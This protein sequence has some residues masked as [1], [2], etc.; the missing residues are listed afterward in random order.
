[1]K[2][3]YLFLLAVGSLLYSNSV[4]QTIQ[5]VDNDYWIVVPANYFTLGGSN[6]ENRPRLA[7][8]A[9]K[10]TNVTVE[11]AA[12]TYNVIANQSGM[13]IPHP[14]PM[15]FSHKRILKRG[16]HAWSTDSLP[17]RAQLL[18]TP[19]EWGEGTWCIPTHSLGMN[20]R[21]ANYNTH[22]DIHHPDVYFGL[23]NG[24]E[25]AIVATEV[26][27]HVTIDFPPGHNLAPIVIVLNAGEAYHIDCGKPDVNIDPTGTRITANKR[28]AV[29]S[30]QA[31]AVIPTN[32]GGYGNA[33][34]EEM[35]PIE[36]WGK[37]HMI[38][39]SPRH[40]A[41]I[42]RFL[43]DCDS[44]KVYNDGNLIATINGGQF[45]ETQLSGAHEIYSSKPIMVGEYNQAGT[46]LYSDEGGP[47]ML[48][49]PPVDCYFDSTRFY[50]T[51]IP[52]V[53]NVGTGKGLPAVMVIV[54]SAYITNVQFDGL[55][56]IGFATITNTYSPIQY[57]YAYVQIAL[58]SAGAHTLNYITPPAANPY[59]LYGYYTAEDGDR[60]ETT[61]FNLGYRGL[62]FPKVSINDS[63]DMGM[64]VCDTARTINIPIKNTGSA[65][66]IISS[67]SGLNGPKFTL[68]SHTFPDTIAPGMSDQFTVTFTSSIPGS[69]TKTLFLATN[70]TGACGLPFHTIT[71]T[72]RKEI[73]AITSTPVVI[74][75]GDV[76]CSGLDTVVTITNVGTV[77]D[78]LMFATFTQKGLTVDSS[79]LPVILYLGQTQK[80]KIHF[81]PGSI[82]I[83]PYSS[84]MDVPALPCN[85]GADFEFKANRIPTAYTVTPPII[86]FG[87]TNV[88]K[89]SS[90]T[91]T[92]DN[93][94]NFSV[95]IG[96]AQFDNALFTVTTPFPQTVAPHSTLAID[97]TCSPADTIKY[98]STLTLTI[99]SPCVDDRKV[100][101]RVEGV[102]ICLKA[103]PMAV[104]GKIPGDVEAIPI[105]ID[106][107]SKFTSTKSIELTVSYD[108]ELLQFS[109]APTSSIGRI[110]NITHTEG[111]VSLTIDSITM[112]TTPSSHVAD[113]YVEALLAP[114]ATGTID[115]ASSLFTLSSGEKIEGGSCPVS[116]SL[117]HDCVRQDD[118][119]A[120]SS[121]S[122]EGIYPNPSH[123]NTTIVVNAEGSPVVKIDIYDS[124]GRRSEVLHDGILTNGRHELTMSTDQYANGIYFCRIIREGKVT[125]QEFNVQ[126]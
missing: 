98:E 5:P 30:G 9:E 58:T 34:I 69:Y 2:I 55:P 37:L 23:G 108:K 32:S 33:I 119:K 67:A 80:I 74:D 19:E 102:S 59:S 54:P 16:I 45:Y 114:Y 88:N 21:I 95:H 121:I 41:D 49:V 79:S 90:G 78:T 47:S 109:L 110:S 18:M 86:D 60:D 91:F 85:L 28:I 122:I 124:F 1:M 31:T 27:T 35:L 116:F 73:A 94:N 64:L 43:A 83:G 120:H 6:P 96:G 48:I 82:P 92:F 15:I 87:I 14:M 111:E 77:N 10:P 63:V 40:S 126:R 39:L 20:Y 123:G 97:F 125:T 44:T 65:P 104:I 75:F 36:S 61:A 71:I 100:L 103:E 11:A 25:F 117:G 4:G 84:V 70:D 57:S 38:A 22:I 51:D 101:V 50:Q 68:S 42:F 24:P 81:N 107:S 26:N 8:L 66:L 106:P 12:Q 7:L 76:Q 99:D 112:I 118:L 89:T 72:A 105:F 3:K 13:I 46:T 53:Q 115:V 56:V 17:F 113:V 93:Q 52:D 29:F 62:Q